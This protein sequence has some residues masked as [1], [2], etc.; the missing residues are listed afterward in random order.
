MRRFWTWAI[1]ALLLLPFVLAGLLFA[2]LNTGFGQRFA[3]GEVASLSGGMVRIEGLSGR[4]P[5]ALRVARL[6]VAD[7]SGVWLDA[8]GLVLDWS[9]LALLHKEALIDRLAAT[10]LDVSRAPQS[11][12]ASQS[13]GGSP[14]LP[15]AITLKSL[16]IGRLQLGRALAGQDATLAV[17]GEAHLAS[18]HSGQ[19]RLRAT[20]LDAPGRY[21]VDGR[22]DDN[23]VTLDLAASEP[24][25]GLA[26]A[27]AALPKL[28]PNGDRLSLDAKLAGPWSAA[29]LDA[30][31]AAGPM[32][33][34]ATGTLDLAHRAA[35]LDLT[36]SAPAMA[37]RPDLSWGSIDIALHAQGTA[38]APVASGHLSVADLHA[39]GTAFSRITSVFDAKSGVFHLKSDLSGAVLPGVG[40]LFAPSPIQIQ[41]HGDVAGTAI[42]FSLEHDLLAAR[43]TLR[44]RGETDVTLTL[45]KLAAFGAPAAGAATLAAKLHLAPDMAVDATGT[46]TLTGGQQQL[47][48]LVG[49][50]GRFALKATRQGQDIAIQSL[51]VDG[52]ALHATA[53]ATLADGHLAGDWTLHLPDM[54][55]LAPQLAGGLDL[56]G[57][58]TGTPDDIAVTARLAGD[59][60]V[61][62]QPASAVNAT[63][64]ITGLPGKPQGRIEAGGALDGSPIALLATA[65]RDADGAMRLAISRADWKSLHAEGALALAPGATLPTGTISVGIK[66]LS[67]L[68]HLEGGH[69]AGSLSAVADLTTDAVHLTLD[70]TSLD[71]AGRGVA[72]VALDATLQDPLGQR[73]TDATLDITGLRAAS[74]GGRLSL[75]AKGPPTALAL[76]LT[77]D[78]TGVQGAPLAARAA[79]VA[80]SSAPAIDLTRLTADW[81]G[82]HLALAHKLHVDLADG[83]VRLDDLALRLGQAA[84]SLKGQVSPT[85][86]LT[87][88]LRDLP[89][90]LAA[91]FAPQAK[92]AGTL[93]ADAKLAGPPARPSGTIRLQA[94]GV[95]AT[96]GVASTLRPADLT[97]DAKLAG[98]A[99]TLDARLAAGPD[100]L[101]LSGTAPLGAGRL[102]LRAQGQLDLAALN[103]V[104]GA[105]GRQV[106]GR[107]ALDARIGGT[108]AKP[109]VAGSLALS[110]GLVQDATMGLRIH[111]I[112]A[113]LT[114]SGTALRLDSLTGQA[115]PG[116]IAAK[117]TIGLTAPMPVSLTVTAKNARLLASEL[118]HGT[119]DADLAVK[120]TLAAQG[121]SAA[122]LA[123]SGMVVIGRTEIRIPDTLPQ[124]VATLDV[125]R[126]GQ[127]PP[128]PPGPPGPTIGLDITVKAPGEIFVRGRGLE[129]EL[130][131]RLHI[132]GSSI[133][134]RP[135]GRFTLRRGTFTL[136]GKTLTF[137]TGTLG[138][139]GGLPVDPT[140]DFSATTTS[141]DVTATLAVTGHASKPKI[142]LSSSPELPQDEILARI[143]FNSSTASLGPVQL[144]QIAAAVAQ[145]AGGSGFDPLDRVRAG[146]GLDRLSVNG[147]AAGTGATLEAGRALAPGVY[148]GAKQNTAGTGTKATVEID[149]GRGLKLQAGVGS[150]GADSATGASGGTGT[151]VG[152]TYQFDY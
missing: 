81:R 50:S 23:G 20:R 145:M 139:D 124:G 140:L 32:H 83:K 152:V 151:D 110:N 104:L 116:T 135:Q 53:K 120:G 95:R 125:Q 68:D 47:V 90:S 84:L 6:R 102:D 75:T 148:V 43:G 45:P 40:R 60:A 118:I 49:R 1:I 26:T 117:G 112:A 44:P 106:G 70:G 7:A 33:L 85:L 15:V 64:D 114:G 24:D 86:D 25:G 144:A 52:T 9:P 39:F 37:P 61:A 10:R 96:A 14:S 13:S 80:D 30:H 89:A 133:A 35:D 56:T 28:V 42:A 141:G 126:P 51:S 11:Q 88:S 69:L 72:K 59:L 36:A 76:G 73:L 5:D 46:V 63:V 101:H 48:G 105:E 55:V 108:T 128:K 79:A 138:F 134:P 127:Q 34:A 18:L 82:Q 100:R 132:L 122:H 87:A 119:L 66:N 146:L 130:Q 62:G 136:A 143:L 27:M 92:L 74:L 129:A 142:T 41:A 17:T 29:K 99:A 57:H 111:D 22:A 77:A 12:G 107:L 147:N 131:G 97:L 93:S 123:A 38:A 8:T 67:D 2:L 149:L 98:P 31:V 3:A 71:M 21:S 115:G 19:A 121:N 16:S 65:A 109:Q 113:K 78:L 58:A 54:T 150:S 4:F 103:A 91:L 94:K 137:D